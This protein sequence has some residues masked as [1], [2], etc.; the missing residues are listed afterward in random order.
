MVQELNKRYNLLIITNVWTGAYSF[1]YNGAE[2]FSGMPAFQK[3]FLKIL[4][5][6]QVNEIHLILFDKKHDKSLLI[7]DRHKKKLKIY[8]FQLENKKT[9]KTFYTFI[10]VI[11]QGYNIIKKNNVERIIG[12]GSLAGLTAILSKLTSIKDF[13]RLYGTF[14]INELGYSKWKLF[15]RHPLEFLTFS[16]GNGKL[17]ITNDGTKGDRVFK[18]IGNPKIDFH[19]PLNGVDS[20][21]MKNL[22]KPSFEIKDKYLS[23]VARI[24]EWKQQHVLLLAL[25]FLRRKNIEFPHTY[26][27]GAFFDKQYLAFLHQCILENDL[28]DKVT[29]VEGLPSAQAHYLLKNSLITFSLYSTSNLGNVFLEALKL[30]VPIIALNDTNSLELIDKSAYFE[31]LSTEPSVIA[32]A[33]L[34]LLGDLKLRNVLSEQ[35]S[36]FASRELLSWDERSDFEL[37]LILH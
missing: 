36:A 24:D 12:F 1:F 28:K 11:I 26:L 27:V 18:K 34:T 37:S 35:A 8:Q 32:E 7:P 22:E 4:E 20:D 21:I 29:I 19:F 2:V 17:L 31:V 30:G 6:H 25:G 13:R 10:K 5:H 33:I 9:I 16:L 3:V 14:L 15:L 23:Y